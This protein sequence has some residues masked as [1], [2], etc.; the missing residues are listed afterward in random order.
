MQTISRK[1]QSD[2]VFLFEL[3]PLIGV[4]YENILENY[5]KPLLT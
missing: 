4:C 1:N 3:S 2:V 5:L